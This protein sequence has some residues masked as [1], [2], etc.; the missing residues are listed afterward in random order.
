[1]NIDF[2]KNILSRF[3]IE[4][5][6]SSI[7]NPMTYKLLQYHN[8]IFDTYKKD[9]SN[10]FENKPKQEIP[11]Y[12]NNINTYSRFIRSF[13]YIL[14]MLELQYKVSQNKYFGKKVF[15]ISVLN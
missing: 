6:K 15:L 3:G 12:I 8:D 1:M 5:R 10:I 2:I 4:E 9:F 13:V 7:I 11:K 14:N